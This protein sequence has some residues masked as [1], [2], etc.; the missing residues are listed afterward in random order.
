[1]REAVEVYLGSFNVGNGNKQAAA[2]QFDNI[3][4]TPLGDNF[5]VRRA[6]TDGPL[7]A[8]ARL[9]QTITTHSSWLSSGYS[10]YQ[11]GLR[12]SLP[13]RLLA[14]E[15]RGQIL[16][17][18]SP[19]RPGQKRAFIATSE[20]FFLPFSKN[21]EDIVK[22]MDSYAL[23]FSHVLLL[24]ADTAPKPSATEIM[25]QSQATK[26]PITGITF[27]H[28]GQRVMND[29]G[30]PSLLVAPAARNSAMIKDPHPISLIKK[31][32]TGMNKHVV[33]YATQVLAATNAPY[34]LLES[35]GSVGNKQGQ[36]SLPHSL[37]DDRRLLTRHS[38]ASLFTHPSE[39]AVIA[40]C[41]PPRDLYLAPP[42]GIQEQ[43]NREWLMRF[44]EFVQPTDRERELGITHLRR[45][46]N[47]LDLLSS[48]L[49][50]ADP[51]QTILAHILALPRSAWPY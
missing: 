17:G 5:A 36:K 16:E 28:H 20:L 12:R 47:T 33:S 10:K 35:D 37:S 7:A 46:E 25:Q 40:G 1:M 48:E 22:V 19:L 9:T 2:N 14:A 45:T 39:M 42:R 38:L 8:L 13:A 3:V 24:I 49:G 23:Y 26:R 27:T 44:F 43:Q 50:I 15:S 30:I 31:S 21:P 29:S 18:L 34:Y 11:V 32:G 41:N 6:I 51:V 4:S